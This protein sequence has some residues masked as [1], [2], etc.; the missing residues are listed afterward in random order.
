MWKR[1]KTQYS[2]SM[3]HLVLPALEHKFRHGFGDTKNVMCAGG[4]EVETTEHFLLCC[5]VHSPQRLELFDNLE[6]VDSRFWNLKVKNKVSFLL[7]GSQSATSKTSNDEILKFVIKYVIIYPDQCF[8]D[9]LIRYVPT[10]S[11]YQL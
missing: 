6:K 1:K 9:V 10:D 3:I 2:Q 5:H 8:L 4:S 7:Y 11:H